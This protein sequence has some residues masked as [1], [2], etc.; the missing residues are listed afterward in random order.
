MLD[1]S[2][3]ELV[4]QHPF[5]GQLDPPVPE[6]EDN[7]HPSYSD[8]LMAWVRSVEQVHGLHVDIR[9]APEVFAHV[10]MEHELD[11]GI[12]SFTVVAADGKG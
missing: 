10:T 9:S 7:P 12:P 11:L 1:P 2:A 5:L 6:D 8:E 4:R 3:E